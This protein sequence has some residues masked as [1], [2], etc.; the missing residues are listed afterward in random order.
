MKRAT[1]GLKAA[2][3]PKST[4]FLLSNSNQVYINTILEHHKL[5]KLFDR[6]T[7]NP[8]HWDEKNQ[9]LITRRISP[10]GPQHTC[11]VGCSPNMC[12]G[13]S[14]IFFN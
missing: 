2:S 3:S 10:D 8:S 6:I 11:Q 14:S 1:L 7:T 5:T 4:F 9:L 13:W 12:K